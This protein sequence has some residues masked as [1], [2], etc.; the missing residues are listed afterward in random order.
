MGVLQIMLLI[1]PFLVLIL[2]ILFV[3]F[4]LKPRRETLAKK[5]TQ[6]SDDIRQIKEQIKGSEKRKK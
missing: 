4:L 5:E 2:L 6:V 3:I 1:I